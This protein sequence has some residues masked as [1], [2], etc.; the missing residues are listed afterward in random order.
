MIKFIIL[1]SILLFLNIQ[2]K[3]KP[4]FINLAIPKARANKTGLD[5]MI[6]HFYIRRK[7]DI[8]RYIIFQYGLEPVLIQQIL[9]GFEAILETD[10]FY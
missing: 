7:L 3:I 9:I 8:I 6:L 2:L 10:L 4:S 5:I 1:L